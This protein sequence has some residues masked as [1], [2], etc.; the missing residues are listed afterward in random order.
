MQGSHGTGWR[1][2]RMAKLGGMG[3][4]NVIY[5]KLG[6]SG[7]YRVVCLSGGAH[8]LLVGSIPVQSYGEWS[9]P[10]ETLF[11]ASPGHAL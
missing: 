5:D 6:G 10:S 8:R 9:Y 7:T 3:M 4:C 11:Q 2:L 1:V